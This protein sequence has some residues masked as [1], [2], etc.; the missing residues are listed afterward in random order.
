MK[1]ETINHAVGEKISVKA[2]YD[3]GSIISEAI[4]LDTSISMPTSK[5]KMP[6]TAFMH[7]FY[8]LYR[9]QNGECHLIK[10][11]AEEALSNNEKS[12]FTRAYQLKDIVKIAN[13]PSSVLSKGGGLTEDTFATT[14]SISDLHRFVKQFDKEFSPKPVNPLLLN[15]DGTPKVFYHGTRKENGDFYI[16]DYNQAKRKGGLGFKALGQGNYFTSVELDG[17]E[18]YGSRVIPAYLKIS[19]PLVVESSSNFDF[20]KRVSE[21]IGINASE[22][23]YP[24][25]QKAMREKG[26]DGVLQVEGDGK[27]VIAVTFDSE[28]IKSATENRKNNRKRRAK[29]F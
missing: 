7:S 29:R 1:S 15:E 3:I 12:V 11:F 23:S 28:Q 16:F 19:N 13:I 22:M 6:N 4:L 25:I 27:P 10:I 24:S 8:T 5:T 20:K 14:I 9:T 17:T 21:K 26:Y 2:I 18:L